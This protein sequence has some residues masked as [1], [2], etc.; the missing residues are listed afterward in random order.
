VELTKVPK[1][2]GRRRKKRGGSK[3]KKG[4]HSWPALNHWSPANRGPQSIKLRVGPLFPIL[5]VFYFILFFDCLE[6]GLAFWENGCTTPPFLEACPYTWEGEIFQ[7]SWSLKIYL[8]IPKKKI[9]K[10]RVHLDF[11][12]PH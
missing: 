10:F 9:T 3:E 11:H 4:T 12:I 2:G 6:M 7:S 8:F 5:L 1:S